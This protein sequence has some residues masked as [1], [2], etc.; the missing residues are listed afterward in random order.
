MHASKITQGYLKKNLTLKQQ[1]ISEHKKSKYKTRQ[2][3]LKSD[4]KPDIELTI[5]KKA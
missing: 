5:E 2:G 1:K 4:E 3:D